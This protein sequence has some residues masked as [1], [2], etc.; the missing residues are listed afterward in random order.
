MLQNL[1]AADRVV[2]GRS[3]VPA[4]AMAVVERPR[5]VEAQPDGEAFGGEK[6]APVVVEEGPI[7]LHPI[8]DAAAGRAETALD[9][10]GLPEVIDSQDRRL[11]SVPGEADDLVGRSGDVLGD[12]FLKEV[13]G[14]AG[15]PGRSEPWALIQVVAVA[16]GQVAGGPGRFD[17]H[18][19]PVR[20]HWGQYIKYQ[21]QPII[22]LISRSSPSLA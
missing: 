5:T 22:F 8:S 3:A 19:E 2:E 1:K 10:D 11:A 4:Q 18:L 15:R 20:N 7:C 21:G 16:A 13:L 9:L 17:E 6:P 12:V 14:H